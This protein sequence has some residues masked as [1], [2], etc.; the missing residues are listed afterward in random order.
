MNRRDYIGLGAS[1]AL[2]ILGIFC[3]MVSTAS[4]QP[5]PPAST[6][7]VVHISTNG[8]TVLVVNG[9]PVATNCAGIPHKQLFPVLLKD[10]IKVPIYYLCTNVEQQRFLCNRFNGTNWVLL[11]STNVNGPWQRWGTVT[12]TMTCTNA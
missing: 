7:I 11:T 4:S 2:L 10:E 8:C 6:N 9:R 12:I 1:L 3:V 5:L